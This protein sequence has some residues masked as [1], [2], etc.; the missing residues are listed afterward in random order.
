MANHS[1]KALSAVLSFINAVESRF[2]IKVETQ[3]IQIR[4]KEQESMKFLK[5]IT[6]FME[7]H[8]STL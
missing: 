1:A 7:I 2:E 3:A 6:K 8:Q 5:I 4:R